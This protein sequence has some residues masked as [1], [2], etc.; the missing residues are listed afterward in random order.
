[1]SSFK[2][3]IVVKF[4]EFY[5]ALRAIPKYRLFK[6]RNLDEIVKDVYLEKSPLFQLLDG[7]EL[8]LDKAK[9]E[10]FC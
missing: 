4:P 10:E 6:A 1:M 5:Q 9:T 8:N 7:H 3:N 2:E